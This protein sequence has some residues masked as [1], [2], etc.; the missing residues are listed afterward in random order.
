MVTFFKTKY[1][2][3]SFDD[4]SFFEIVYSSSREFWYLS[5]TTPDDFPGTTGYT[6][7]A[8]EKTAEH[9]ENLLRECTDFSFIEMDEKFI[10]PNE[11]S[12]VGSQ[13]EINDSTKKWIVFVRLK[14]ADAPWGKKTFETQEEA[15]AEVLRIIK[16]N[17]GNASM[18]MED[19]EK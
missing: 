15:E 3:Q 17:F 12:L 8:R 14:D 18:N 9:L 16:K 7:T 5:F 4:I 10:N 2:F 1:G 19:R 13:V 6:F 11:I